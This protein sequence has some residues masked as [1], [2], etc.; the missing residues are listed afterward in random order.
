MADARTDNAR[1]DAER[2][3]DELPR[4]SAFP[5]YGTVIADDSLNLWVGNYVP[6]TRAPTTWTVF[7]SGGRMLGTIANPRGFVPDH[8]GQSFL[9]GRWRDE[10]D[11]EHVRLY[12]LSK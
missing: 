7:D 2:L 3:L 4:P 8:I 9:L 5:A 10:L 12:L 1:R 11:V 6:G